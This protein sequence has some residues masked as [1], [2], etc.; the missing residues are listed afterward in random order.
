MFGLINL[1]L[2]PRVEPLVRVLEPELGVGAVGVG[3][4]LQE[5]LEGVASAWRELF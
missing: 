2:P 5:V 3:A 1:Y 4:G